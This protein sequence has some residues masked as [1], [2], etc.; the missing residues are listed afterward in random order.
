[1]TQ[2]IRLYPYIPNPNEQIAQYGD[3]ERVLAMNRITLTL[4]KAYLSRRVAG[5]NMEPLPADVQNAIITYLK[6]IGL[7]AKNPPSSDLDRTPLF[8]LLANEISVSA[9][10]SDLQ[11]S[12]L[13]QRYVDEPAVQTKLTGALRSA[14]RVIRAKSIVPPLVG[15]A[16]L[17][18]Y[19]CVS[20]TQ[21]R[22]WEKGIVSAWFLSLAI[23][24]SRL[25]LSC[26][27][28][29]FRQSI[30]PLLLKAELADAVFAGVDDSAKPALA[31]LRRVSTSAS[32]S[33]WEI[34]TG[35]V[36]ATP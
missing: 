23:K 6:S 29:A 26:F 22:P 13:V 2:E 27:K 10:K 11:I 32:I 19:V 8:D 9:V 35:T 7:D 18:A 15:M 25:T 20:S 31:F 33:A 14:S 24:I 5:M 30:K 36:S 1:M 3:I 28:K 21:M 16:A 12:Q 17:F 34:V 4:S